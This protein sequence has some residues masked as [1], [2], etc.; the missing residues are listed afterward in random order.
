MLQSVFKESGKVSPISSL[1]RD[2]AKVFA[3]PMDVMESNQEKILEF[4]EK[5]LVDISLSFHLHSSVFGQKTLEVENPIKIEL[6]APSPLV[7]LNISKLDECIELQEK[8][9][10]RMEKIGSGF[11]FIRKREIKDF[12]KLLAAGEL[13]GSYDSLGN[14]IGIVAI[15]PVKNEEL[16]S[17]L[18]SE[19][20]AAL[21]HENLKKNILNGNGCYISC[22]MSDLNPNRR[23]LGNHMMQQA[24]YI[25]REE[26]NCDFSV[27][28]VHVENPASYKSIGKVGKSFACSHKMVSFVN[29]KGNMVSI[30]VFYIVGLLNEEKVRLLNSS[31]SNTP[32]K[33]I[34]YSKLVPSIRKSSPQDIEAV[35]Q[36]NQI[37]LFDKGNPV[38]VEFSPEKLLPLQKQSFVERL[39]LRKDFSQ[40]K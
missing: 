33:P 18:N 20:D 29:V 34:S 11:D 36:P 40:L 9:F 25:A 35:L 14:L 24:E 17:H 3:V 26:L 8:M 13:Y 23:G 12:K 32:S 4:K 27:A 5:E 19:H 6:S 15:S 2:K 38:V 30:P 31:I 16:L 10:E 7:K 22:Y 28:E 1:S 21:I 39:D 37:I